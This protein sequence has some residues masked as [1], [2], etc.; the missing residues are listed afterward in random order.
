MIMTPAGRLAGGSASLAVAD[1][2]PVTTIAF[3]L[4]SAGIYRWPNDDAVRQ[5]LTV[6]SSGETTIRDATLVLFDDATLSLARR[7]GEE[8]GIS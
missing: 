1:Q 6:L 5:A 3:P 4:I 2:L 8:F 7:V